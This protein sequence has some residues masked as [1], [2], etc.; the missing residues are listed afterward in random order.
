M[1]PV[2]RSEAAGSSEDYLVVMGEDEDKAPVCVGSDVTEVVADECSGVVAADSD[3]PFFSED[4]DCWERGA[5]DATARCNGQ[6]CAQRSRNWTTLS[7]AGV[8]P[9]R[10][11]GE[12]SRL[13]RSAEHDPEEHQGLALGAPD[14][15]RF[16]A[17]CLSAQSGHL[18]EQRG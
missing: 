4:V 3:N 7:K 12:V 5:T 2:T 6:T 18:N 14:A 11:A 9:F 17:E 16:P 8:G 13:L 10:G 1:V 15:E